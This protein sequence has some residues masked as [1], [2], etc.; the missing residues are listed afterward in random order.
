MM[1]FQQICEFLQQ[2][3][4]AYQANPQEQ[5][6]QLQR[7]GLTVLISL[8]DDGEFV[9]IVLPQVLILN[10]DHPH[11][12]AGSECLDYLKSLYKLVRWQRDPEDGE[13]RLQTDLPLEDERQ[14]WNSLQGCLQI[15]QQGRKQ[16]QQVLQQGA[17]SGGTT[18]TTG[19]NSGVNAQA[20]EQMAF[21][22]MLFKKIL[23]CNGAAEQIYPLLREHLSILKGDLIP[24]LQQYR[25][26][27]QTLNSKD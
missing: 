4:W 2:Q 10:S 17:A 1:H 9:K 18:R 26:I 5:Q 20:G 7:E 27:L 8:E 13:V 21:L 15:A 11:Y 6:L 24:A 25:Q 16:V 22:S 23:E 14:F 19:M 12:K 3:N